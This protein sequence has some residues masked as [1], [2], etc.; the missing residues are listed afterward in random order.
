MTA[1]EVI[2]EQLH[3][4]RTHAND[5]TIAEHNRRWFASEVVRLEQIANKPATTAKEE[6]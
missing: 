3:W 5:P 4:A 1:Q 6:T 2:A